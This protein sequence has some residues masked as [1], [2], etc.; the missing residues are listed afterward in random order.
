MFYPLTPGKRNGSIYFIVPCVNFYFSAVYCLA[1]SCILSMYTTHCQFT[2]FSRL[3][4][5][6]LSFIHANGQGRP[7]LFAKLQGL[8]SALS[9]KCQGISHGWQQQGLTAA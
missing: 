7:I 2:K 9:G 8:M 6:H 3:N 4:I 1:R 5:E